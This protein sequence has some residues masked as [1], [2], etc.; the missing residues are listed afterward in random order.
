VPRLPDRRKTPKKKD[1]D[2]K[3]RKKQQKTHTKTSRRETK[4][5]I[6]KKRP[7]PP[8]HLRKSTPA[9]G[10]NHRNWEVWHGRSNKDGQ[11]VA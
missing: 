1:D 6:A 3:G 7:T 4:K 10:G 5:A 8:F 9:R 11:R 2:E